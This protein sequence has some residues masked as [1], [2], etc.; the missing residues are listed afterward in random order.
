[1]V[2]AA[3][4]EYDRLGEAYERGRQA[5][6]TAVIAAL[7]SGEELEAIA[8]KSKFS[9]RY[10]RKIREEAGVPPRAAGRRPGPRRTPP[11]KRSA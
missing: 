4:Q 2:D 10:V 3:A 1:M 5:L 9:A 6:I 8:A 7:K 11:R